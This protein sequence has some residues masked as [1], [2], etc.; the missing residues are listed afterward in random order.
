M[1]RNVSS[2]ALWDESV[3]SSTL[4][5]FFNQEKRLHPSEFEA[6]YILWPEK[7]LNH[8]GSAYLY[9]YPKHYALEINLK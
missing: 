2:L 9:Y 4:Q 7:S 3:F 6:V 5:Q 8:H 1:A